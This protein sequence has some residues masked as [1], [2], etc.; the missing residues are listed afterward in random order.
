MKFNVVITAHDG[1]VACYER[2]SQLPGL[3]VAPYNGTIFI[4]G[5]LTAP[6]ETSIDGLIK[7]LET[8]NPEVLTIVKGSKVM[9][10]I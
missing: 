8:S 10:Q 4:N 3:T 9:E 1:S 7:A 2:I 5:E 6:D